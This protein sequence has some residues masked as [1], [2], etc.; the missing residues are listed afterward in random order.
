MKKNKIISF[1]LCFTMLMGLIPGIAFA[2]EN[3]QLY[4]W[5]GGSDYVTEIEL[6]TGDSM[7]LVFAI[8]SDSSKIVIGSDYEVTCSE[9]IGTIAAGEEGS[10]VWTASGNAATGQISATKD[11]VTYTLNATV[12][13]ETG[14]ENLG[15]AGT[16]VRQIS[17]SHET[18][19][20][21][22]CTDT[23]WLDDSMKVSATARFTLGEGEDAE[24]Y[25]M[26]VGMHGDTYPGSGGGMAPSLSDGE[27]RLSIFDIGFYV[28]LPGNNEFARVTD[29]ATLAKIE[30]AFGGTLRLEVKGLNYA[31][32]G[33]V[34]PKVFPAMWEA[35]G[36]EQCFACTIL[37]L[38]IENFGA[39]AITGIGTVNG[40]E[41]RVNISCHWSPTGEI[42]FAPT[43]E[44]VIGQIND[45]LLAF[46]P[47]PRATL[48]INLP[49]GTHEGYI[50]VPAALSR[51]EIVIFGAEQDENHNNN[52]FIRGGV[53][54][55]GFGV[56]V[57]QI[58]F[59]GA[60]SGSEARPGKKW[61]DGTENVALSGGRCKL[62]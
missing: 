21:D 58:T 37:D 38:G 31:S 49:E 30:Q 4:L 46:D 22:V 45:Y 13:A 51:L 23:S 34:V 11:G 25:Y 26:G 3:R 1:L 54:S 61:A 12:I 17:E 29:S 8:D 32:R 5:M 47:A 33:F 20:E 52:T 18:T 2:E 19:A 9:E 62:V 16:P 60:G 24:V 39:Y 53:Q 59:L 28:A 57:M 10:F 14:N 55:E 15:N 42:I 7:T 41:I 44:D 40:E 27:R 43:G 56:N 36:D 50:I 35:R 48:T 6:T